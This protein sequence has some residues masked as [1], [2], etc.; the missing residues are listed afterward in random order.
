MDRSDTLTLVT[1]KSNSAIF[2][3]KRCTAEITE[4]TFYVKKPLRS[5]RSL[6]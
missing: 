4:K 5:L 3:Q 6:Q 1:S 2:W